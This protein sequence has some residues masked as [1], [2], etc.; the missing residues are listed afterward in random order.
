MPIPPLNEFILEL[1]KFARTNV[2]YIKIATIVICILCILV[3]RIILK[4]VNSEANKNL[5][6]TKAFLE[7]DWWYYFLIAFLLHIINYFIE[8]VRDLLNL[9]SE[10]FLNSCFVFFS[11]FNNIFFYLS[12][13]SLRLKKI[14]NWHLWG[15]LLVFFTTISWSVIFSR[16]DSYKSYN[17]IFDAVVSCSCLIY[18]GYALKINTAG[19]F[20]TR[21]EATITKNTIFSI[22][23]IYGI[24]NL[25]LPSEILKLLLNNQAQSYEGLL[26]L[27]VFICKPLM[28]FSF[29]LIYCQPLVLVS[30]DLESIRKEFFSR[31]IDINSTTSLQEIAKKLYADS[32]KLIIVRPGLK[33]RK[34]FQFKWPL[35]SSTIMTNTLLDYPTSGFIHEA[36]ENC[37]ARYSANEIVVP[38]CS[39]YG[40]AIGCLAVTTTEKKITS[41]TLE[42][43]NRLALM[44]ETL[45]QTFRQ[46]VVISQI[47]KAFS[48]WQVKQN[49]YTAQQGIDELTTILQ[50]YLSPIE[51][52]LNIEIGFKSDQSIAKSKSCFH[53][54]IKNELLDSC[55]MDLEFKVDTQSNTEYRV[56]KVELIV[57]KEKDLP[58]YPTLGRNQQFSKA[59][60]AVITD[61]VLDI[62]RDCFYQVV[63]KLSLRLNKVFTHEQCIEEI[64]TE[65]AL[66]GLGPISIFDLETNQNIFMKKNYSFQKVLTRFAPLTRTYDRFKV[67]PFPPDFSGDAKKLILIELTDVSWILCMGVQ[68][69]EFGSEL[70]LPSPWRV[71]IERI[72]E[73][74]SAT[75]SRIK[76]Q[77]VYQEAIEFQGMATT[78]L[79]IDTAFHQIINIIRSVSASSILLFNALDNKRLVVKDERIKR[80]IRKLPSEVKPLEELS[81]GLKGFTQFEVETPCTLQAA[82]DHC[83]RLLR[84]GLD[85]KRIKLDIKN[86][87]NQ[88][89]V[90]FPLNAASIAFVNLVMNAQDAIVSATKN[91]K[92]Y[93]GSSIEIRFNETTRFVECFISNPSYSHPILEENFV[94]IF[95]LGYSSRGINRGWGLYLVSRVM[96]EKGGWVKI[97]RSDEQETVFVLGFPKINNEEGSLKS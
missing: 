32:I 94:D 60:S 43:L 31:I 44:I 24:A 26:I 68:R 16:I 56:G 72:F 36:L 83:K 82:L 42:Y 70:K 57:Y 76:T 89:E 84:A 62:Y 39:P 54:A 25:F 41:F 45:V 15:I 34:I 13:T 85:A 38:I 30:P 21:Y 59:L 47:S 61:I 6:P 8:A 65:L 90:R 63:N 78:A 17:S 1:S 23:F 40:A 9:S 64:S 2:F 50:D 81:L 52:R 51:T 79:V 28:F 66:V 49:T 86:L 22:F 92:E 74:I 80:I 67:L 73:E 19:E 88:E 14:T 11:A 20:F 3:F 53:K 29:L 18:A 12:S 48:K 77:K 91:N 87:P 7:W 10:N 93:S 33:E 71:F 97:H 35:E 37:I 75:L 5:I 69:E 46:N 58:N 4:R 95:K 55:I 27:I 96:S